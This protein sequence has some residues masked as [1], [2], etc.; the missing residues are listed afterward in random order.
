MNTNVGP[1]GSGAEGNTNSALKKKRS[2][3]RMSSCCNY[4]L[5]W[6]NYTDK[7]IKDL[8]L[9]VHKYCKIAFISK[10]I[11]DGNTPHLQGYV[12]LI[13]KTRRDTLSKITDKK[14]HWEV[15]K[16]SNASMYCDK[17]GNEPNVIINWDLKKNKNK[18]VPFTDKLETLQKFKWEEFI[19][20]LWEQP[21]DDRKIF[22]I[23]EPNGEMGKTIYAR[24]IAKKY[25]SSMLYLTGKASDMKCA[26]ARRINENKKE[27]K[28][29]LLDFTMSEEDMK[30]SYS[31]IEQ[32][33]NGIFFSGKYESDM[34]K[35]DWPHIVCFAN[36]TPDVKRLA[37][38]R[39]IVLRIDEQY[40]IEIQNNKQMIGLG[41]CR[42]FKMEYYDDNINDDFT[43]NMIEII[44]KINKDFGQTTNPGVASVDRVD[45]QPKAAT[46]KIVKAKSK[47][48]N[49]ICGGPI[50]SFNC[51]CS[52][53]EKYWF[54][55]MW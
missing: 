40:G 22:W 1:S 5:T 38:N 24:H 48:I 49:E 30:I 36:F 37:I 39:W 32:I 33:K 52:K 17:M 11:G 54:D 29:V 12:S 10:E 55:R 26:V 21:L 13:H 27:L 2:D 9:W 43:S 6:N 35:Y 42:N 19:D 15:A 45:D 53:C 25:E 8:G 28:I 41:Q 7:N 20:L 14:I 50:E 47:P 16:A 4:T 23:W 46:H 18:P 3:N 34:V 51:K 31:G 44:P